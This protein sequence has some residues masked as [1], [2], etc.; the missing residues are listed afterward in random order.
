[1]QLTVE[2]IEVFARMLSVGEKRIVYIVDDR[3]D[4]K[5]PAILEHRQWTNCIVNFM[6][7]THHGQMEL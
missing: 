7:A 5:P 3:V 2:D 6:L 4:W 1:M